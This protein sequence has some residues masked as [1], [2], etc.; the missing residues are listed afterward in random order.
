M[1][2]SYLP[3]SNCGHCNKSTGINGKLKSLIKLSIKPS[4]SFWVSPC[5]DSVSR[6]KTGRMKKVAI[7]GK[8]KRKVVT[9]VDIRRLIGYSQLK[10][11][12]Y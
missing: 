2:L 3:G 7:I 9:G 8:T 6:S 11:T 5:V 10:S 4:E 12:G 1:R